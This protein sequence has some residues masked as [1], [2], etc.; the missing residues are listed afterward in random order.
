MAISFLNIP[1]TI[2]APGVYVEFDAS[3]ALQGLSLLAYRALGIG[4]RLTAGTVAE[5][6]PT[7][8]TSAEQAGGFFGVGSQLH[9]MAVAWFKNNTFTE[10]WMCA[11]N[12]AGGGVKATQTL[13][14]TG[15]A[16]GAGTLALLVNGEQVQVAIASGDAQNTIA[17]AVGA[18]INA[19]TSLPVTATV[20]TNVVT[21]TARN[22]GTPGND[23]DIRLNYYEGEKTPAGVAV[24]IAAG[25]AGSG[26]VDVSAVW[27]VLGETFYNVMFFAVNDAT[28]LGRIDTE[29]VSRWGPMRMIE[30]V[31]H[32]GFRGTFS[33]A[34]TKGSAQNSKFTSMIAANSSPTHPMEWAAATAAQVAGSANIQPNR[35]FKSLP[36]FN[37]LPPKSKDNYSPTERNLLLFDGISTFV[38]D[39]AGN[40]TL[41]RVISTYQISPLSA[42]DVTFL[43]IGTALTL[44]YLR[45]DWRTFWL[46][47][48][49]RHLLAGD[50]N[51]F[52]P[53]L[54]IMTPKQ[55]RGEAINRFRLWEERGLVDNAAQY[56]KDLVVERNATDPNRLDFILPPNIVNGLMVTGVQIGFILE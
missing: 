46:T 16:T 38:V 12:D 23:I 4:Q 55:G 40:A 31:A 19:K 30:A 8:V 28:N 48:Y 26:D 34:S 33:A 21:A 39:Q 45:Y 20:S 53:G 9:R 32:T 1:P 27:T 13:T 25:V 35:P 56:K 43:D 5:L 15:P 37:V 50:G 52:G 24:A 42:E 2:R 18:A 3:H 49:P 6:V 51:N 54:A 17:T 44:G 11:Q 29:L 7:R 47:H 22:T 10:L 36:L 14:V 41:D